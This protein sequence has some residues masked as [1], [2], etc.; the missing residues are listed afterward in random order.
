MRAR[1][2]VPKAAAAASLLLLSGCGETVPPAVRLGADSTSHDFGTLWLGE[3]AEHV[4]RLKNTGSQPLAIGDVRSSCG[5]A[6]L[7]LSDRELEPQETAELELRLHADKGPGLLEKSATLF[8]AGSREVLLT[9]QF[10][11]QVRELYRID[12]PLV[13]F[14]DVPLGTSARREARVTLA[15]GGPFQILGAEP[16]SWCNSAFEALGGEGSGYRVTI[17][18][19]AEQR[20]GARLDRVIFA[21]DVPSGVPLAI[22]VQVRIVPPFTLQPPDSL[23]LGAVASG[24]GA[25]ATV[26]IHWQDPDHRGA[27]AR[28]HAIPTTFGGAPVQGES[29]W[30]TATLLADR[31]TIEV[32]VKPGSP[33]GYFLGRVEAHGDERAPFVEMVTISGTVVA[34]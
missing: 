21:T 15:D 25:R 1:T 23:D 16:R 12:P 2:F 3:T 31:S 34:R 10:R 22:P 32:E 29:P 11:V 18:L 27:I 5:C 9:L 28:V 30:L 8:A 20:I 17:E 14:G 4:F 24:R 7:F 13:D 6:L 26:E 19:P 33:A